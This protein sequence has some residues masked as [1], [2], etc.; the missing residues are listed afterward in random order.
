MLVVMV[1][2]LIHLLIS[3]AMGIMIFFGVEAD[4]MG[5]KLLLIVLAGRGLCLALWLNSY[6]DLLWLRCQRC[7]GS[8]H[9]VSVSKLMVVM[10]GIDRIP[11]LSVVVVV[12]AV[13]VPAGVEVVLWTVSVFSNLT[14]S[15]IRMMWLIDLW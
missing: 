13:S 11:I 7:V 15:Q 12:A 9:L 8:I 4:L 14:P 5:P 6:W 10:W 2:N 3:V 1:V